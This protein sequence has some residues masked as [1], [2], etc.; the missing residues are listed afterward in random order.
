MSNTDDESPPEDPIWLIQ[1]HNESRA[2]AQIDAQ[3]RDHNSSD[4]DPFPAPRVQDHPRRRNSA[5]E[6]RDALA[7]TS[8]A[9]PEVRPPLGL[10]PS[11]SRTLARQRARKAHEASVARR[12][13]EEAMRAEQRR[14]RIL[15]ELA[16]ACD[17]AVRAFRD[18]DDERELVDEL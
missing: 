18:H 17:E 9:E 1:S 16:N 7:Y 11:R 4:S 8:L 3:D 10:L 5:S 15:R 12:N 13:N 6:V 14:L 2:A